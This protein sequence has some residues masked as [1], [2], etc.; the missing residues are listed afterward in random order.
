MKQLLIIGA[1]GYGRGTYDIARSMETYGKEFVVKGY[2]D[3]KKDALTGYENYPPIISSVEDYQIEK[4]D[5]FVCAL[6]D[7]KYKEKYVNLILSKGGEFFTLI[8]SSASIGN[9]AK[10]GKGCI[11][12]YNTQIDCDAVVGDFVNVQTNVVIGHDSFI[13]DWSIMDCFSFTGGFAKIGNRCTLH[14]GAIIIPKLIIG[15]NCTINAGSMVIR[16]VR[17]GAT[18]MGNPAREL[19]FPKI[20]K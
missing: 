12:G 5:V 9:N 17:E 1:R 19:L 10:I 13:G 8:H 15:D 4:N 14:T 20:D 11:V 2:L 16:N 3:D 6:G 18:V 7:V